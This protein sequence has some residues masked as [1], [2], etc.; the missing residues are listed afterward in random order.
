MN[1]SIRFVD[2]ILNT[3]T[4]YRLLLYVLIVLVLVAALFGGIGL[5]PF[6]ALYILASA[7]FLVALC[8]LA[9]WS[10][11]RVFRAATNVES[12]YITALILALIINPDRPASNLVTLAVAAI[13]ATASKYVLAFRRRHVFNPAAIAVVIT[14]YALGRPPTWWVG[15]PALLPFVL[16]AGVLIVRKIRRLD[17]VGTFFLAYF[18]AL[19]L[20]AIAERVHLATEVR[21]TLLRSPLLFLAFVMLTEPLTMPPTRRLR[22]VYGGLVG[23]LI[24]PQ[25]HL[26]SLY[27]APE[28]ALLIGNVFAWL[29]SAK[30]NQMMR[31]EERRP[32]SEQTEEFVFRQERPV[33]FRPGQYL[34][35]T[36]PHDHPD[37]RGDRRF[38]TI[39]S[40]PGD[41]ALAIGVEFKARSSTFKKHLKAM[42][43]GERIAA[44]HLAGDFVLPRDPGRK[45]AFVA[46]GIGVTPFVSMIRDLLQRGEKRDIVVLITNRYETGA[47]YRDVFEQ[48]RIELGVR[49]VFTLTGPAETLPTGWTG[50]TGR[51][52]ETFLREEIPDY[53]ERLFYICGSQRLVGGIKKVLA[54]LGVERGSVRSDYFP[55]LA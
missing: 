17:M 29:V 8:V 28:V 31:L 15:A 11:A 7:A 13:A 2:W 4:M 52:D 42:E 9:N 41:D 21:Q 34:E 45:L 18:A 14:S 53:Q 23:F 24:V 32:I 35:W 19:L 3:T 1:T 30:A 36:L 40:P 16:I 33:R 44:G 10:F 51:I 37:D 54:G 22:M 39:S 55:G 46:G 50:R 43:P 38:F 26:G 12:T 49:T 5:L 25:V 6:N 20:F 48:V 27:F 47:A